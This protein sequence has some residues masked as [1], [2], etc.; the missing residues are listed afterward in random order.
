MCRN[1]QSTTTPC[2]CVHLARHTPDSK[3]SQPPLMTEVPS[4]VTCEGIGGRVNQQ[5]RQDMGGRTERRTYIFVS[6]VGEGEASLAIHQN[7]FV[8]CTTS[9]V[10]RGRSGRG[11]IHA[12]LN[13]TK[14][15]RKMGSFST[16]RRRRGRGAHAQAGAPGS[17][18]HRSHHDHPSDGHIRRCQQR[19]QRTTRQQLRRISPSSSS[20]CRLCAGRAC[21]RTRPVPYPDLI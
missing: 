11:Q 19:H 5:A 4:I 8:V 13:S 7:C 17:W 18:H 6:I 3:G 9:E 16:R 2:K 14:R 20:L 15:L 21:A 10:A 12:P 1:R